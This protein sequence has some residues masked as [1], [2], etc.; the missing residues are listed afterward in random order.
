MFERVHNA[1]TCC[2]LKGSV[3]TTPEKFGNPSLFLRF[4]LPSTLIR[5]ENGVFRKRS[6]NQRHCTCTENILQAKL[7]ENDDVTIITWFPWLTFPQTQIQID[8]GDY[9]DFKFPW[10][11]VKEFTCGQYF[12]KLPKLPRHTFA[13]EN[14]IINVIKV[15]CFFFFS[16]TEY[17]VSIG[18]RAQAIVIRVR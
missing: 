15:M 7:F 16:L 1:T 13:E 6:S 12:S 11:S 2:S 10:R 9:W 18:S 3:H 5:H 8:R 4:G 14:S 17:W